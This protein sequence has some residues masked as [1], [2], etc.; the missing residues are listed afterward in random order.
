MFPT[1]KNL[2][3]PKISKEVLSFW[4]TERIFEKSIETRE[5]QEQ[6]IFFEG[7]PSNG[8]PGIHH[9]LARTIKDIFCRYKTQKGYQVKEGLDGTHMGYLLNWALKKI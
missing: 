4:A 1:Y 2:N 7:P 8:L 9:L 6:F 5:G 3:I